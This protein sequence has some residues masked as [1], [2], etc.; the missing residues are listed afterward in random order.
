MTMGGRTGVGSFANHHWLCDHMV[1]LTAGNMELALMGQVPAIRVPG[2]IDPAA[3]SRVVEKISHNPH[4]ASYGHTASGLQR[5]GLCQMEHSETTGKKTYFT[6]IDAMQRTMEE[7]FDGIAE[8][9]LR[10]VM[11]ALGTV[12]GRTVSLAS[13]PEYGEYFAGTFRRVEGGGDLHFDYA[14]F[15]TPGWSVDAVSDQLT[16]NLY[17]TTPECG[18]EL[19]VYERQW[20]DEALRHKIKDSIFY[21]RSVLEGARCIVYAPQAGDLVLFNSRQFHEVLPV[22]AG[23]RFTQSSFV[24]LTRAGTLVF[25]S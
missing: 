25:W 13:E 5:L 3:C 8:N 18:G 7:I 11:L 16:W 10:S 6:Q 1:A 4:F 20:D 12:A 15:E 19:R 9:F 23:Q 14:P 22:T 2:F 21:H 17:L 24:G